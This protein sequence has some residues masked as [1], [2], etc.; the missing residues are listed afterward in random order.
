MTVNGRTK[1]AVGERELAAVLREAGFTARRGQQFSGA[2]GD[3][4]VVADIPGVHIECKRVE[5]LNIHQAYTQAVRDAGPSFK[6]PTVM[7][8]RNRTPWLVTLSLKDFLALM[9]VEDALD[10]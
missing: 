9:K 1:G 3:P 10:I 6:I 2:N 4:D 5:R 8:R 7:H